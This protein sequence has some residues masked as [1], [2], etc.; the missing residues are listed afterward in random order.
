MDRCAAAGGDLLLG[1]K[2][3]LLSYTNRVPMSRMD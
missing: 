1:S 3:V 2:C